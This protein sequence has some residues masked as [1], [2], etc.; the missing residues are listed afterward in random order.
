M[1][2]PNE[3]GR[4]G[5]WGSLSHLARGEGRDA[6]KGTQS[7][8][9]KIQVRPQRGLSGLWL[10]SHHYRCRFFWQP[11]QGDEKTE[12]QKSGRGNLTKVMQQV[13]GKGQE[14]PKAHPL[15]QTRPTAAADLTLSEG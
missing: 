7:G 6:E 3:V 4:L 13:V 15:V 1:N 2:Q 5:A 12:A 9:G 11:C 8:V 14:R 10:S